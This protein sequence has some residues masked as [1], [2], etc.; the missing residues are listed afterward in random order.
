ML[1]QNEEN[2]TSSTWR[3]QKSRHPELDGDRDTGIGPIGRGSRSQPI[4]VR[5]ENW[6]GENTPVESKREIIG[7]AIDELVDNILEQLADS[8]H[9][10]EKLKAQLEKVRSIR[11]QIEAPDDIK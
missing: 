11:Q 9:R 2:K 3:N 7:G 1:V 8:E 4:R 10:T 5:G 6:E